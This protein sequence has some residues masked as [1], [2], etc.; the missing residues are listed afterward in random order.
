M[1][2]VSHTHEQSTLPDG[3]MSNVVRLYDQD[4]REY[5]SAFYTPQG[6]DMTA[7]IAMMKVEMNEHLAEAEFNQIV[8][9]G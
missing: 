8:G 4:A 6:Y 3:S 7:R 2:I 1:P 9:V 5:M